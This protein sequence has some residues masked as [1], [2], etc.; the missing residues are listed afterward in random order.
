MEGLDKDWVYSGARR[1]AAYPH[2]EPGVYVF[3]V[4]GSNND[5]VWNEEG[6]SITIIITPPFWATWWFR[7]F[8]FITLLISVGGS[9]RYVEMRKLKRKIETLEQERAV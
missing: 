9:I 2:L 6:T 5:G 1:Y 7:S 3:R 4:K 8:S